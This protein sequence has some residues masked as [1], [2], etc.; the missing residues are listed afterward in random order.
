MGRNIS[1]VSAPFFMEIRGMHRS[2]AMIIDANAL[3]L[4]S[5]MNTCRD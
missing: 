1:S 5:V 2:A 3:V 4:D